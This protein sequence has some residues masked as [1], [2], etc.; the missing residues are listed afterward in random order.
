M[1]A[2]PAPRTGIARADQL[3]LQAKVD[4]TTYRLADMDGT[5][6]QFTQQPGSPLS[7]SLLC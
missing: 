4:A 7:S 6:S 1:A 3:V 2:F 5:I